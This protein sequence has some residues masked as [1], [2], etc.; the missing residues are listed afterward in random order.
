MA[1][2]DEGEKEE[3]FEKMVNEFHMISGKESVVRMVAG[4]TIASAGAAILLSGKADSFGL[5]W[6]TV[7]VSGGV[8][9]LATGLNNE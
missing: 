2:Q 7:L 5:H 9:I 1:A 8:S 4:S 3:K 6:A